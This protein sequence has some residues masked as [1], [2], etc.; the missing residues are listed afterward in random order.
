MSV[1]GGEELKAG[2]ETARGGW[3]RAAAWARSRSL[4]LSLLL[5]LWFLYGCAINA[6]NLEAF[7]LQQAGVEALAERGQFSLEGSTLRRFQIKV[8]RDGDKPFG[9]TFIYEG[10]QYAAKQ[11]GQFMAGAAIY[12]V[13][14]PLG[15][16]YS[17]DY[18]LAA[19]LVTFFT[20]SLVTAAAALAVFCAAR[21]LIA[22]PPARAWPLACA[23]AYGLATTAF[24]YSGVAHHDQIATGYLMI[25]FCLA[26]QLARGRFEG[27]G[28]KALLL[29]AC[30]GLLLGLAVTT[31]MLT[32]V[33][34]CV[35]GLYLVA[36]CGRSALVP[37]LAGAAVGI[38]PLLIYN[39]LAFGN[40]LLLANVAGGYTDTYLRL[41]L[42]DLPGKVSIYASNLTAYAPVFWAGLLGLAFFPRGA[43]RERLVVVAVVAALSVQVL[44]IDSDGGCQ[45]GPRYLLPGM[46]FACLGLAGF[47][48]LRAGASRLA[49][50]VVVIPAA[51]F[52]L[53]VNAVGAFCGAMY[54]TPEVFAPRHYI[55]TLARGE[56]PALPLAAWLALPLAAS[57]A[58]L[59]RVAFKRGVTATEEK[60]E[61]TSGSAL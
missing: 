25:A 18:L 4:E 55:S 48:H 14:R 52:S 59:A 41:D 36:S 13:L 26:V 3:R 53:F 56:W 37:S 33:L 51:S 40:P 5:S 22:S 45:Y 19:A 38:A 35:V 10:R 50:L 61:L 6:A 16:S 9:D 32:A 46:P 8:Y 49:A 34:A 7:N 28:A 30:A 57:A 20:A 42:D 27:R 47:A 1:K 39:A 21:E 43:R 11:P 15:L 54:C 44:N 29:A 24:A 17:T 23:L 31:S 12:S 2:S 58:W 60:I